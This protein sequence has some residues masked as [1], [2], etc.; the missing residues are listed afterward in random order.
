MKEPL[1]EQV[2]LYRYRYMLA[3]IV[4]VSF[5]II[6]IFDQLGSL[7]GGVHQL[8]V[9]TAQRSL[10]SVDF[11]QQPLNF[12]FHYLQAGSIALLGASG[13]ALRLPSAIIGLA[14]LALFYSLLKT[15]YWERIAIFGTMLLIGSSWFLHFARFGGPG[16][17]MVF[18]TILLLYSATKALHKKSILWLSVLAFAII[19]SMYTPLLPYI[20]LLGIGIHTKHIISVGHH[21]NTYLLTLGAAIALLGGVPLVLASM[22]DINT[23]QALFGLPD[24]FPGPVEYLSNIQYI[25]SQLFWQSE[26]FPALHLGNLPL[27]DIFTASMTALGLYHYEQSLPSKRGKIVL[28]SLLILV[29]A[30]ALNPEQ[31]N[32]AILIPFVYMLAASGV[33]TL[34]RQW[35]EIFPKNPIARMIAI[36]PLTILF[37]IVISYHYQRYFIAWARNADVRQSH[38][39]T[40]KIL[41]TDLLSANIPSNGVT[42]IVAPSQEQETQLATYGFDQVAIYTTDAVTNQTIPKSRYTYISSAGFEALPPAIIDELPELQTQLVNEFQKDSLEFYV[43]Y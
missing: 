41:R 31:R 1:L 5:S 40:L 3:Y 43:F 22:Q 26:E 13:L 27:L 16:I 34:I 36:V 7:P 25:F 10:A 29:L 23:L 24:S 39:Q 6:A 4:M 38:S 12:V 28:G 42:V 14:S 8:E 33:S 11:L 32:L 17:L 20:V 15:W 35:N 19:L 21:T 30:I 9:A 2:L 37:V 18:A